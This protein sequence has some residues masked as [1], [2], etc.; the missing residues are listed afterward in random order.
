MPANWNGGFLFQGG[1]GLNG[2]V[3]QPLG[4][5]AAG[6]IPGLAR[7]FAV[8]TTDTGHK[9]A[10]FDGS[11]MRDQQ[12]EL[13][14]AYSAVGK[15][16]EIAKQIVA[17]YYGSAARHSYLDGCSTGGV[18][19]RYPLYFDGVIS[20]DPAMR[21]GYSNLAD[22]FITVLL[23]QVAPKN[24]AGKPDSSKALS[25]SDK[26]LV[27]NSI[28]QQCDAA[29]GIKDGLIFSKQG[30][31]FDPATLICKGQKTDACLTAQAN[32]IQKGFAGPKTARGVPV[33]A[34]FPFDSGIAANGQGGI[35]G[36]LNPGPSPVGAPTV[37][38]QMNVDDSARAIA[39]NPRTALSDTTSTDF[40]SFFGHGGKLILYHGMSDPW[41]SPLDTLGYYE[42]MAKENG[43]LDQIEGKSRIYFVPGMGHCQGGAATL[44]KFDALTAV[45]NWVGK[46]DAPDSITATGRAF[47]GRSRPLCAWPRF[48]HYKGSGDSE[49]ARNFECRE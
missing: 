10:V 13:D 20:G 25:D 5:Q 39:T 17:E 24:S 19:Q 7:G 37:A 46:G 16:T 29:D 48:A 35:P 21:T 42:Q 18:T 14:F 9:G 6:D 44:D 4:G 40:S 33:Y 12:A 8:V 15:V 38:T 22:A 36:L 3:A 26:K 27:V 34:A 43:G 47:P 30:C 2:S 41:F 11:F 31:P 1:G 45:V 32:A 28:L 49:D 23:N